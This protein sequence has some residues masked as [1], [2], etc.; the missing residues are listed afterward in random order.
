MG[1]LGEE[2]LNNSISY[3][4]F[5]NSPYKSMKHSTYFQ[6]Y[7]YLFS[8][9]INNEITFVEI[10]VLNGGSLFF[11]QD[12]FGPNARIIGIDFNPDAK[13]WEKF[14]FEIFIGDQSDR[15]LL[16]S[17]FKKIGA[18]DIL[19]DDGG[20]TYLQ[21][22]T[23]VE[24]ALSFINNGGMVV[25]EDTFTSYRKGFGQ[26][27]YSFMNYAIRKTHALNSNF[28]KLSKYNLQANSL[29]RD[30]YVWSVEFFQAI[31]AFRVNRMSVKLP[32]KDVINS[33]EDDKAIDYRFHNSNLKYLNIF[34]NK[35]SFL[36]FLP[37]SKI[38]LNILMNLSLQ[39]RARDKKLKN[40]FN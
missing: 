35:F 8:N 40:F 2:N 18:I 32:W 11:W 16:T 19:L 7:D 17:I 22:I 5:L 36:K 37:G 21:Q 20:H 31:V 26:K 3:K 24:S 4:A 1:A 12:F 9:Y 10:G 25:V 23:T 34:I 15:D 38:M 33:G 39:R 14:G 30:K 27:K 13:K 6:V 28:N 29:T